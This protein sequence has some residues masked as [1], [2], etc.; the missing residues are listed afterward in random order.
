MWTV[1]RLTIGLVALLGLLL[2]LA[3][4]ADARRYPGA[5]TSSPIALSADGKYLWSV[6]PGGDSVS[7]ISTRTNKVLTKVGVGDEPESVALDPNNRYAY[8]ANAA[9]GSVTVIVSW[10]LFAT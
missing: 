2:G 4:P 9:S 10:P 6:N 7:V 8:V 3:G 1:R 5:T